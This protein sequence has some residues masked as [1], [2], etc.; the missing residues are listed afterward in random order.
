MIFFPCVVHFRRSYLILS[1]E[2][3]F[4]SSGPSSISLA[5]TFLVR[6]TSFSHTCASS[7]TS[8]ASPLS[9]HCASVWIR[10][11]GS[12][13]SL[14]YIFSYIPRV[15]PIVALHPPLSSFIFSPTLIVF[16]VSLRFI[17]HSPRW[18]FLLLCA[19]FSYRCAAS[20]NSLAYIFLVDGAFCWYRCSMPSPF[21]AYS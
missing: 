10:C 20:S 11:A 8:V 2:P 15:S 5:Y 18:C 21:A 12:S 7:S 13:S 14:A 16:L 19:S 3:F 6:C 9:V 1:N 17:T 4:Y